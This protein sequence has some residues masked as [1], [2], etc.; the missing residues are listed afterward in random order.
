MT[1][2]QQ[3]V[4]LWRIVQIL[5]W[6]VG[7]SILITLIF[8][9]DLGMDLFWNVLI[10]LAPAIF[11]IALGFWRNVCPLGTTS[12]L[13][14]RFGVSK[15]KTI[16]IIWQG[17]LQLIGLILLFLLVPF[18]HVLLDTN[19]MATAITIVS[20]SLI[21]FASGFI[22][23][24]KSFWCSGICPVYPV[25]KLYGTNVGISM[26]NAQC[27]SCTRCISPCTD[28]TP[29]IHPLSIKKSFNYKLTGILIV[30]GFPGF[31]WGWYQ[32][33]QYL[34]SIVWLNIII[35]YG[36]PLI[37]LLL[38]LILYRIIQRVLS[39]NQE[40]TLVRIFATAAIIIYYWYKLPAL[41]GYS[42]SPESILV[43]Y[44]NILPDWTPV[45]FRTAI[46]L[47]FGWWMIWRPQQ[48]KS[49]NYRPPYAMD[50]V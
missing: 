36:F 46:I 7:L 44:K 26:G 30:A 29:G 14:Q 2:A 8:F 34:G 4:K 12:L 41:F 1:R 38:S 35:S 32:V 11:A 20:L 16:S 48:N 10:P 17:R 40:A 37:G 9:P 5:F 22:Y 45:A 3:R 50:Q 24:W 42:I 28:S 19:A 39:K 31:V 6:L 18:R 49:R 47:F 15:K 21:A 13:P 27:S 23:D 25:E 33:P 43:N